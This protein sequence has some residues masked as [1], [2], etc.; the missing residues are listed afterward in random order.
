MTNRHQSILGD[1]LIDRQ[2]A[3][4]FASLRQIES[5]HE[6]RLNDEKVIDHLTRISEQLRQHFMSEETL[7]QQV[8]VPVEEIA[9][10]HAEHL[11][12]LEEVARLHFEIMQ[13]QLTHV[14]QVLRP[15]SDWVAAHVEVYD[16]P[17]RDYIVKASLQ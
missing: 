9:R 13:G 5:L 17:L 15:L 10:H 4:L 11:R 8:A 1:P 14:S 7:M 6:R 16:A 3:D 12:I 2:H